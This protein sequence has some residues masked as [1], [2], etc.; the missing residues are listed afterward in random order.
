MD[1]FITLEPEIILTV[2][3]DESVKNIQK[4]AQ[5]NNIETGPLSM[6]LILLATESIT[7]D[8]IAPYLE[9]RLETSAATAQKIS[10]DF[11][12]EV[13]NPFV[14][15]LEFLSLDSGKIMTI[16]EEKNILHDIF[17]KNLLAELKDHPIIL[18][19]INH[20]IF[21]ILDQNPKF[22]NELVQLLMAN[23]EILTS[24]NISVGGKQVRPT[25]GNW[26]KNFI[27]VSGSAIFDSVAL[28]KYLTS[29]KSA[30]KLSQSEKD[31]IR[32]I[33]TI[34]RN[35]KFFPESMPDD[36]GESWQI[37]PFEIPTEEKLAQA[38]EKIESLPKQVAQPEKNVKSSRAEEEKNKENEGQ[39]EQLKKM[40]EKYP[41][42]SLERRAV[43]A[44]IRKI[45]KK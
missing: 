27:E 2:D 10:A 4:V 44:E 40:A 7:A 29:S 28:S 23:E 15:R 42:N 12:A 8:K 6:G 36:T 13:V 9:E 5:K 43:E 11:V 21:Y 32:K 41:L 17:L 19:A 38:K 30:A 37:L 45:S 14:K 22:N 24:G 39:L 1:K 35:L 31:G 34:Y 3:S 26:L 33:L 20:Q 25:I 16:E 18:D